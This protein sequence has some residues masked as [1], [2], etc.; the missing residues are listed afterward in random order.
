MIDNIQND[1]TENLLP[2]EITPEVEPPI[3]STEDISVSDIDIDPKEDT[4]E[5]LKKDINNPSCCLKDL[6]KRWLTLYSAFGISIF[7][8]NKE[9][10]ENNK[11]IIM[12]KGKLNKNT[13]YE[14][15]YICKWCKDHCELDK[16]YQI[17]TKEQQFFS[18]KDLNNNC[19]DCP[20]HEY[21]I[22]DEEN[23][24]EECTLFRKKSVHVNKAERIAE[25]YENQD[26]KEK[27]EWVRKNFEEFYNDWRNASGN[28][29]EEKEEILLECFNAIFFQK[30]VQFFTEN[31]CAGISSTIKY[32]QEIFNDFGLYK[33]NNE[34]EA[35]Q[36]ASLTYYLILII[37][38]HCSIF[39]IKRT[40][41]YELIPHDLSLTTY[42]YKRKKILENIQINQFLENSGLRHSD[43]FEYFFNEE[44][45]F[46]PPEGQEENFYSPTNY[47][48]E[49]CFFENELF[50]RQNDNQRF[51]FL[52]LENDGINIYPSLDANNIIQIFDEFLKTGKT[53]RTLFIF[54]KDPLS[55]E[56][57]IK[58]LKEGMESPIEEDDN[59][60][61]PRSKMGILL[62]D[63]L[64]FESLFVDLNKDKIIR[65]LSLYGKNSHYIEDF[66]DLKT[67][68]D[69]FNV[70]SEKVKAIVSEARGC[71]NFQNLSMIKKVLSLFGELEYNPEDITKFDFT[72]LIKDIIDHMII[73]KMATK[74]QNL[75]SNNLIP[76]DERYD[77][78]GENY[79]LDTENE[80]IKGLFDY[81][82]KILILFC[83]NNEGKDYIYNSTFMQA[84]V[85]L[86]INDIDYINPSEEEKKFVLDI[87]LILKLNFN[88]KIIANAFYQFF[89]KSSEG[90][91]GEEKK[92][93]EE[94][95]GKNV[96]F[97]AFFINDPIR[98][99]RSVYDFSRYNSLFENIKNNYEL[100]SKEN[101]PNTEKIFE[102]NKNQNISYE[103]GIKYILLNSIADPFKFIDSEESEKSAEAENR[104][105]VFHFLVELKSLSNTNLFIKTYESIPFLDNPEFNISATL[106]SEKIP[107]F[108]K[109]LLLDFL[110]QFVMT[111]KVNNKLNSTELYP[112]NQDIRSESVNLHL[113]KINLLMNLYFISIDLLKNIPIEEFKDA[114]IEQNGLYDF[115]LSIIKAFN[116]LNNYISNILTRYE[117]EESNKLFTEYFNRLIIQFFKYRSKIS[118]C[119]FNTEPFGE[120]ET[121][122]KKL[123]QELKKICGKKSYKNLKEWYK[124][125]FKEFKSI[126]S[127]YVPLLSDPNMSPVYS[128]YNRFLDFN[129][130]SLFSP[131][132]DDAYSYLFHFKPPELED[133]D[134]E[135]NHIDFAILE[136][137]KAFCHYIEKEKIK[138]GI[139][140]VLSSF[141]SRIGNYT[142]RDYFFVKYFIKILPNN[143][144]SFFNDAIILNAFTKLIIYDKKLINFDGVG[145]KTEI[146]DTYNIQD[147]DESQIKAK[148]FGTVIR[149]L[150]NVVNYEIS[151]SSSFCN[152]KHE[153]QLSEY[154]NALIIFTQVLGENFNTSFHEA[155]FELQFDL[156]KSKGGPIAKYNEE[157]Q[158][159]LAPGEVEEGKAE[160]QD[161]EEEK[162]II[163]K[164]KRKYSFRKSVSSMVGQGDLFV[165]DIDINKGCVPYLLLLIL[166]QKI[167]DLL[168]SKEKDEIIQNNLIM[169][170][171]SLTN[172]LEEFSHVKDDKH[173]DIL[174]GFLNDMFSNNE[175]VG[176]LLVDFGYLRFLKKDPKVDFIVND[177]LVL[178]NVYLSNDDKNLVIF[179]SQHD[180]YFK[181]CYWEWLGVEYFEQTLDS[182]NVPR[183]IS[184]KELFELYNDKKLDAIPMFHLVLK[185][186]EMLYMLTKDFNL[187]EFEFLFNKTI[188]E[189]K[190]SKYIGKCKEQYGISIALDSEEKEIRKTMYSFLNTIFIDLEIKFEEE[191]KTERSTTILQSEINY[192]SE[193][194][195]NNYLDSVDRSSAD[196]KLLSIYD[197]LDSL[198]FEMIYNANKKPNPWEI[199]DYMLFE[200]LNYLFILMYNFIMIYLY[201]KSADTP[202]QQYNSFEPEKYHLQNTY[203]LPF[204]SICHFALLVF[205]SV[206]W[207]KNKFLVKY[208]VD[209]CTFSKENLSEKDK[210][211]IDKKAVLFKELV[212]DFSKD[213]PT[214][215]R[216]FPGV[217]TEKKI[218][219]GIVDTILLNFQIL[220]F[221]ICLI[222]LALYYLSSQ[223][224]LIAPVLLFAKFIPTLSAIF[225]G[226]AGKFKDLITVYIYTFTALYVFS[227]AGFIM[228]PTMFNK[229]VVYEIDDPARENPPEAMCSSSVQCILYF[230]NFGL[231]EGNAG[232]DV[233]SYRD[234]V[235]YYFR[236]FFFDLF[237]NLLVNMIFAN[238]F[239]G[240]I[241]DAFGENRTKVWL[242]EIDKEEKCFICQITKSEC[243]NS[244]VD[245]NDH[246]EDHSVWKYIY[247]LCGIVLK[248]Q[249]EFNYEENYVWKK[250]KENSIGWFPTSGGD[251]EVK[252]A[253]KENG[254][255]IK[256]VLDKLEEIKNK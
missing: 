148:I 63:F 82:K 72:D 56:L 119:F 155:M 80:S 142:L 92:K 140:I 54:K 152:T 147:Y 121:K 218:V 201:Y 202:L 215:W 106:K 246:R 34:K 220:P 104:Q 22:I 78:S 153:I 242:N 19:C 112:Y 35:K 18:L 144:D 151:I 203:I 27:R 181:E 236:Q 241:T 40:I 76:V 95:A 208:F 199:K 156:E 43:I 253:I 232:M 205:V 126:F 81:I 194:S 183:T 55:K 171:H 29:K 141:D 252:D 226:L 190:L 209:L 170:F 45:K 21:G 53:S 74:I 173:K 177:L 150:N 158:C 8:E 143:F 163:R 70:I 166:Y 235:S 118:V 145:D 97:E 197:N 186:Y 64:N 77:E 94:P 157:K 42:A 86:L 57:F 133:Q 68:P 73:E 219:V 11:F 12:Y 180:E 174:N 83:I 96:L 37:L 2:N 231:T 38:N 36:R 51:H 185:F 109:S 130:G 79:I 237:Y 249:T 44:E 87:I 14:S 128:V 61:I 131:S 69:I 169:V 217:P 187:N 256:E 175:K 179:N 93:E 7:S 105:R 31:K 59:I 100:L 221:Y 211:P 182:L 138:C 101:L 196:T 176:R 20:N 124:N 60:E 154:T 49:N 146:L 160:A 210:L 6:Y 66:K 16:N 24:D 222:C 52:D 172:C 164:A 62:L 247:F 127:K 90:E 159:F 117:N 225:S 85:D 227:W 111:F 26:P 71:N 114:Y 123:K 254:E 47:L 75:H 234:N 3:T 189:K 4:L 132:S 102:N 212:D 178:L 116:S 233:L 238:V 67:L 30:V 99:N 191:N 28:E 136:N 5:N 33:F 200:Y 214:V 88:Q 168:Y 108:M 15:V 137:Y 228:L 98:E 113:N 46:A 245:F 103:E 188:N 58:E 251:D 204:L 149:K 206:S 120:E 41:L 248:G 192:L 139:D 161:E 39:S 48:I 65:V 115:C 224:F 110:L 162:K 243:I 244:H 255:K 134:I 216:F 250:F 198:L 193:E 129:G 223:L 240:L 184:N 229:E 167:L 165:A 213:I 23:I 122:R 195:K 13:K 207:Y 50:R 17:N 107:Y 10:I 32:G 91:E 9:F 135:A 230:L 25:E 1:L 239:T 125:I 89:A 84:L